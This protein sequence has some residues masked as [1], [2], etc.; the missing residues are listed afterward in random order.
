MRLSLLPR[1]VRDLAAIEAYVAERG[2][3][4][5]ARRVAARLRGALQLM[6]ARPE[7]GHRCHKPDVREWSVPGLPYVIPYRVRE[8]RIEILRIF[9]TSRKRPDKW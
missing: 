1:A 2:D 6:A 5:T 3:A 8:D 4:A 7:I 9:H